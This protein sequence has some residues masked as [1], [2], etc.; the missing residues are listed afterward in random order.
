MISFFIPISP[1]AKGRPRLGRFGTYTP[2][3]TRR[4]ESE[5]RKLCMKYKPERPLRGP[6]SL[7]VLFTLERPKTSNN[8]LPIV[9]PD[10]TNF[11]KGVEDSLNKIFW[12]DDS[13]I[14]SIS[15]HKIY[16]T[17]AGILVSITGEGA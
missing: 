16:G 7:Y 6:L 2:E 3:K 11:L 10:L 4:F 13:Q 15:A 8:E 14:V 17:T 12:E 9:R 5:F 1:V